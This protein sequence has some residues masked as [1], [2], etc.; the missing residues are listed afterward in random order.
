MWGGVDVNDAQLLDRLSTAYASVGAPAPT[1]ELATRMARGVVGIADD[2]GTR[3]AVVV[4]LVVRRPRT[5][6]RL[7]YSVAAAVALVVVFSG[8]AVAG[9]LPDPVQRQ[10]SSVASHLGIDLPTPG[11]RN[12]GSNA[13]E[14]SKPTRAT[15]PITLP[16][17]TEPVVPPAAEAELPPS[18]T[19]TPVGSLTG[20]LGGLGGAAGSVATTIPSTGAAGSVTTTIPSTGAGPLP[21]PDVTVPSTTQPPASLPATSPLPVPL[22]TV[23]TLPHLGL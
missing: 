18:P 6:L 20:A 17:T 21:Q 13:T 10:V 3:D 16:G 7:R 22:P 12:T 9:A 15:A 4:P 14:H 19:P 8:L 11:G 1:L 23:P 5:R 2:H